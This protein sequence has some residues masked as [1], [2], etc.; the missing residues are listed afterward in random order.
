MDHLKAGEVSA[1]AE[2]SWMGRQPSV[3]VTVH[4]GNVGTLSGPITETKAMLLRLCAMCCGWVANLL[5]LGKL[6]GFLR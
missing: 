6:K 2:A 5:N 4:I 1:G 3:P